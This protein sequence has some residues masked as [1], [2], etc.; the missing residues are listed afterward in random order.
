MKPKTKLS[1]I[2]KHAGVSQSAVSRFLNGSLE[3]RDDTRRRI[4]AAI[5]ELDYIPNQVARSLRTHA[6]RNVGIVLPNI[7]NPLFAAISTGIEERLRQEGYSMLVLVNKND[8][9][10]ERRCVESLLGQSVDGVIFIGYPSKLNLHQ[11]TGHMK[12]LL[13]TGVGVV[14]INRSFA[15]QE[16][17][18]GITCVNS[19]YAQGAREAVHYLVSDGRRRFAAIMGNWNHPHSR[20]KLQG[21]REALR[22]H[23]LSFGAEFLEEG[24]YDFSYSYRAAHKLLQHQPDAILVANDL[25]AIACMKAIRDQQIRVPQDVA[26]IGYGD[27]ILCKMSTPE[28]SSINQDAYQLGYQGGELLLQKIM[29]KAI[30]QAAI[31]LPTRFVP[32]QSS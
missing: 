8:L 27:T 30:P 16:E 12:K 32:R 14:F 17:R 10:L 20:E 5:E 15:P 25:M 4:E 31:L 7:E 2:A 1:D 3:V 6:T 29:K 21:F 28:L 18:A 19:N 26:V 9:D 13:N 23:G 11:G 24:K 22:Q